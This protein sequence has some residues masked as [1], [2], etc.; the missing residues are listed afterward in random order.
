MCHNKCCLQGRSRGEPT[1]THSLTCLRWYFHNGGKEMEDGYWWLFWARFDAS[2]GTEGL[3][4][5]KGAPNIH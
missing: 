3:G 5:V 4:L 2:F 1:L